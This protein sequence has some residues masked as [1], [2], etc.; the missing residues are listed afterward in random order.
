MCVCV[1]RYV[2]MHV[3]IYLSLSVDRLTQRPQYVYI[4][5]KT[6]NSFELLVESLFSSYY[7]NGINNYHSIK[8]VRVL[9]KLNNISFNLFDKIAVNL[10]SFQSNYF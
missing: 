10:Q 6:F 8:D 7:A 3:C 9:L 1:C 5:Y 2:G 4:F